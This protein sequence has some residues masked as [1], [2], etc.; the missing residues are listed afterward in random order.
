MSLRGVGE[1]K[2]NK[3]FR[4]AVRRKGWNGRGSGGGEE[5]SMGHCAR[6][7]WEKEPERSGLGDRGR[8]VW[9]LSSYLGR[10]PALGDCDCD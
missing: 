9:A 7:V 5:I 3:R 2:G 8:A 1:A 4:G 6:G 10:G